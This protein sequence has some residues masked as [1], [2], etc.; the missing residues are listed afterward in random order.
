MNKKYHN[1]RTALE[2]SVMNYWEDGVGYVCV[3]VVV[4]GGGG[5]GGDGNFSFHGSK[6]LEEFQLIYESLHVTYKSQIITKTRPFKY[7]ENF[8]T[9]KLANFQIKNS[10]IFHISAQNKDCVF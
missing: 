10:N 9:K 5:G 4:M 8:T 7:I 1:E 6:K 2:R 3:C